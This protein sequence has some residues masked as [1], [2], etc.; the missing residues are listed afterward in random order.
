MSE[1]VITSLLDTDMYK[2]TMHAAV[3]TNFPN[4]NVIYKYTNRSSQMSFNEPAIN[5]LKEQIKYLADLRFQPDEIAYL[6]EVI[7]YLPNDY[8]EYIGSENFALDPSSQI[9]FSSTQKPGTNHYDINL[10]IEG[11][12]KDTILYEIPLLALVS[13]AYFKF[14]DTDW[15]YTNQIENAQQKAKK[16]F[17]GG[18]QFS[19]F[20]TRRRR[21]LKTQDL[22]LQGILKAI[23]ED[24]SKGYDKLLLGTSNVLFAKNFG[25]K[26][27][28]TV[29]HEWVMGVAAISNDY[30]NAN[31]DSMDYW[32]KTF[33]AQNAGL[34]LTD[35]FGTDDFLKSFYP[36]YSDA[37]VGVRQ[38][39]GDPEKYAEKIAHHYL[40]VLK[41]P[42]FSKSICFSDS[43]NVEKA[44]KY[45]DA[46]QRN[47]LLA[48][49]GIGTHFT[50]DFQKKSNPNEKSEPL[51]IVIKLLKVNGN[52]AVK[53]SD[54]LGKNMGDPAT[55]RRVKEELGYIEH[56]WSGDNEAHRWTT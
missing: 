42:K 39:S 7:P 9:K 32:I 36:P 46:A 12:W 13:E 27:I 28:G 37:Y 33:G 35:T 4:A 20:G 34:A 17:Q 5:W 45:N 49:F 41:L 3:F 43:L 26:P 22:V 15:D 18:L 23:N 16:L 8:L 19:E 48:T 24:I 2:I 40:D 6:K 14:V 38:D 21:S 53:I 25:L 10:L 47:G 50:N 30:I 56:K 44:I 54:N 31:K 1:P 55:V 11:N 29:A 52:H 51:N